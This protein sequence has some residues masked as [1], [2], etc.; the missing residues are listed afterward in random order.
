MS[1]KIIIKEKRKASQELIT[2]ECFIIP[3]KLWDEIGLWF[4]VEASPEKGSR[5]ALIR[6]GTAC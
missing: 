4:W 3:G 5:S 2:M 6:R 1:Q